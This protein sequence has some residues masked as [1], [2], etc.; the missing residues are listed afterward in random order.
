MS[1]PHYGANP[2]LHSLVGLHNV[3]SIGGSLRIVG[4]DSLVDLSGLDNLVSIGNDLIIGDYYEAAYA[5]FNPLL[6]NLAGLDNVS[7]IGGHLQIICNDSL[8]DCAATSICSYLENPNGAVVIY[9]NAPGCN[10]LEE[11][12]EDCVSFIY[13]TG[14]INSINTFPNPVKGNVNFQISVFNFNRISIKIYDLHGREVETILDSQMQA[15][16][17]SMQFDTGSLSP[18]MYIVKYSTLDT[19]HSTLFKL[20][21]VR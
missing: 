18:G 4:N 3:S 21:V 15:G 13:E 6:T 17:Y 16:E 8:S 19:Q 10:S 11:V 7:S 5:V 12:S 1:I 9:N 2:L 20:V 14:S